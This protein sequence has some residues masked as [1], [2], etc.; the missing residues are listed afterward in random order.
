MPAM[1]SL[2]AAP[3]LLAFASAR[4]S[5]DADLPP[6]RPLTLQVA[7]GD[8]VMVDATDLPRSAAF[9]D[10][11]CGLAAP[12]A[13]RISFLG[14]D[15][16]SVPPDSSNAL[17]GLMGRLLPDGAWIDQIPTVDNVLLQRLHHGTRG[18]RHLVAEAA[19]LARDFGLPGIPLS[20]P[21]RLTLEDRRRASMVRAFLGQPWLVLVEPLPH[22]SDPEFLGPLVNALR[23]LRDRGGAALWL[24]LDRRVWRDASLPVSRRLRIIGAEIFEG[25]RSA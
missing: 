4:L 6:T 14:H 12:A 20:P 13:G 21:S 9:A 3:P 5:L 11:A 8:L 15:W 25:Q 10:A 16:S 19:G 23:R 24:T 17:R 7:P 2:Q 1:P 22:L 18:R